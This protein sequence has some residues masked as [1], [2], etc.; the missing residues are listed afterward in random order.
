MWVV[1]ISARRASKACRRSLE[2]GRDGA[3][4][5]LHVMLLSTLRRNELLIGDVEPEEDSL[6]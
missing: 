6:S 4:I 5:A 1:E 3:A 2:S